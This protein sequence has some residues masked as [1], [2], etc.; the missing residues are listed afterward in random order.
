MDLQPTAGPLHGRVA[1]VT[2]AAQ[3][4][5]A[6][7]ATA[8]AAAGARTALADVDL[9]GALLASREADSTGTRTLGLEVDVRDP[10]SIE[11]GF[12]LIARTWAAP[13]IL[14]N[15]A[16]ISRPTGLLEMTQDEWDT[17]LAVN[18]RGPFLVT[19]AFA[20]RLVAQGRGGHVINITSALGLRGAVRASHY[21]ASKGGLN[22]FTRS[23]AAELAP[24][25]IQVMGAGPG[26][27]DT[28]L[29]RGMYTP[30]QQAERKDAGQVQDLADFAGLVVFLAGSHGLSGQVIARG[31]LLPS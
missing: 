23:A 11:A 3:G 6:A 1:L 31:E 22:A 30:E 8:L 28:A 26:Q 24:H 2:G 25:G 4:I 15:N 13:D 14:V 10:A 18:L 7:L 9:G 5:G 16:G 17:L 29:W 20:R 12:D 19:Q 21:A 27:T